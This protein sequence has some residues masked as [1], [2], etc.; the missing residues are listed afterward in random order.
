ME[1]APQ[2][3]RRRRPGRPTDGDLTASDG[4][5]G[6]RLSERSGGRRQGDPLPLPISA[7]TLDVLVAAL[8]QFAAAI[9]DG[10]ELFTAVFDP[11]AGAS[12]LVIRDPGGDIRFILGLPE[13]QQT[14]LDELLAWVRGGLDPEI[15]PHPE[16]ALQRERNALKRER[17]EL[18]RERDELRGAERRQR[19][20]AEAADCGTALLGARPPGF[21]CIVDANSAFG[22]ITATTSDQLGGL[23][24]WDLVAEEDSSRLLDAVR[25]VADG[26]GGTTLTVRLASEVHR[27]VELFVGPD[28]Y[29]GDPPEQLAIRIRDV[30]SRD[31]LVGEL[32]TQVKRLEHQNTQLSGL[33]R[34][35]ARSV[36]SPLRA[37]SGLLGLL[38][39][40]VGEE[41]TQSLAAAQSAIG[42]VMSM[43]DSAVGF[44]G[45]H[46]G[47]IRQE[48]VD[49]NAA[50]EFAT[51]SLAADLAAT[52]AEVTSRELPVVTGDLAQLERVLQ[53]LLADANA[54]ATDAPPAIDVSAELY[55]DMW[56]IRVADTGT[57]IEPGVRERIFELFEPSGRGGDDL[58]HRGAIGLAA[59]RRI[60][61]Q[62]GGHIWVEDNVPRG[63]VFFFT[64]PAH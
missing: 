39:P 31:G 8:E 19:S 45:A 62:H 58:G 48:A 43:L 36:M 34:G 24:V 23:A 59:C 42:R 7:E 9:P 32:Q 2:S 15:E 54:A 49:L 55:G 33:T 47:I 4:R 6:R 21:G 3:K 17:D 22:R 30:T 52:G 28:R 41:A 16:A 25:R 61:E 37:V 64:V 26:E 5:T 1:P 40:M 29:S 53:C 51:T 57:A 18:R 56:R 44:A 11:G 20:L 60:I 38:V 50:L 27:R 12:D 35:T 10:H 14:R 63:A 13:A 46:S